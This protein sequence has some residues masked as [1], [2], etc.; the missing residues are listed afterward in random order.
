MALISD[1]EIMKYFF[2]KFY[3]APLF[4]LLGSSNPQLAMMTIFTSGHDKWIEMETAMPSA[5]LFVC[6]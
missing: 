4:S 1:S 5:D 6:Q 3:C 2:R